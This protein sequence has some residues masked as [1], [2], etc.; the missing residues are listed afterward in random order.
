MKNLIKFDDAR[1]P[2]EEE[3][4]AV[5]TLV[6]QEMQF[7]RPI[8]GAHQLFEA[9]A[10][11]TP[12]APAL[13]VKGETLSYVQLNHK[14]NQLAHRLRLLG[15][16]PEV[17]VGLCLPRTADLVIA[18]LAIL[19]AGGAYVPLDPAYP[20]D[21]LHFQ[22]QDAGIPLLL[23]VSSLEHLW[24]GIEVTRL[25]LDQTGE[26]N[27]E[28]WDVNPDSEVCEENL[29]Y[30]IYTSGSTGRPKGVCIAHRNTLALV[31]WSLQ[32]FTLDDVRGMV[33]GTSICFDLSIFE[34]F[35]PWSCGG[36]VYLVENGL[37]LPEGEAREQSTLLNM[38]P[39]VMA[40]LARTTSL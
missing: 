2:S 33:A 18:L 27:H 23:T 38:V 1:R 4:A 39:S 3:Y 34:F 32:H 14:A 7:R 10:M 20:A 11:R 17:L 36:T 15:I 29:A 13:V 12:Y 37:H 25:H 30:V 26:D 35:V 6:S 16:G 40:E 5:A 22:V 24:Q 9:Q 19:K 31:D 8:R 28:A 21:R